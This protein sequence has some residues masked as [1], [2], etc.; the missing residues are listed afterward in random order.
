MK[1]S[2]DHLSLFASL[3]KTMRVHSARM[4]HGLADLCR[5]LPDGARGMEIGSFAGESALIMML[6][7]R[8]AHLTCVDPWLPDYYS[9]GQIP[10]AEHVFD[11]VA[12]LFPGRIE[13]R[14]AM[15]A[16]ALS[17]MPAASLDFV[18]VDGNH[19]YAVVR[20]DLI[21]ALC[22]IKP[23][24][25]LCGHDYKFAGS[26]GVTRAVKE[27]VRFPDVRF[28]DYSWIKFVDRVSR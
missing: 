6:S 9:G 12:A 10:R 13:K 14:K 26:P 25:I 1:I 22:A 23:G 4:V 27:L 5:L 17:A 2:P 8:V 20:K 3:P 19:D 24:G 16:A 18:Y 7:G 15:S 21:A 28:P 11:Q